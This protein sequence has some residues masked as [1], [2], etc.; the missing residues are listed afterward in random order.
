M[1][2]A[3]LD[4][5]D[6]SAA[7]TFATDQR[8]G[9]RLTGAHVDIGAVEAQVLVVTTTADSGPGSLRDTVAAATNINHI[10]FAPNLSGSTITLTSGLILLA[11]SLAIDASALPAGITLD[12]PACLSRFAVTGSSLV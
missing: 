12:A 3:P 10:T 6:D 1:S 5:A 4:A 7:N 2:G 11:S 9:P 8:G